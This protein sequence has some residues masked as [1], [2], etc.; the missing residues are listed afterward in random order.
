MKKLTFECDS[1]V[2]NL[3][4][5]VTG[6]C[7]EKNVDLRIRFQLLSLFEICFTYPTPHNNR[8][9]IINKALER[10][11]FST[12]SPSLLSNIST[13]YQL[14]PHPPKKTVQNYGKERR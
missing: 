4:R 6:N 12:S 11:V 13:S 2:I 8:A 9:Q 1:K 7:R 5:N 3:G 14:Y 10:A